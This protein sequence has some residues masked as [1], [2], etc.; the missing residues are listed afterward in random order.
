MIQFGHKLG[1]DLHNIVTE[2][3]LTDSQGQLELL[4]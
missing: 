3:S 4:K 1:N 2:F